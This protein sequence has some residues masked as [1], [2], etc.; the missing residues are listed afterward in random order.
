M[1]DYLTSFAEVKYKLL[2]R[3][4]SLI[5]S[6][7]DSIDEEGILTMEMKTDVRINTGLPFS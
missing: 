1:K 6:T 3:H 2:P 4:L 5:D 7:I